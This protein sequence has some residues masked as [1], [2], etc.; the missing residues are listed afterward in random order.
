MTEPR[1][2]HASPPFC[3]F[4]E[5]KISLMMAEVTIISKV[6]QEEPTWVHSTTELA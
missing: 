6:N 4:I 5:E 1:L 3:L 2:P